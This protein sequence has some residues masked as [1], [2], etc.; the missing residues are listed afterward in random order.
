MTVDELKL[1]TDIK[2][3][4][5]GIYEHLQNKFDFNV[6]KSNK[7]IRRAVERELEIDVD[8]LICG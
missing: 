1:L 7:T 2:I 3:A 4:I 5:E 8:G 6:Y